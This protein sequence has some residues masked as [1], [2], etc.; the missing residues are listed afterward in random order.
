MIVH[1]DNGAAFAR[2]VKVAKRGKGC[3]VET[4]SLDGRPYL[5]ISFP[6]GTTATV[7]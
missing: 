5:P 7:S 1:D 2:V 4:V 6:A 3:R